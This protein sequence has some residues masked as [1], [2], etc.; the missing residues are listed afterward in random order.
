MPDFSE[1]RNGAEQHDTSPDLICSGRHKGTASVRSTVVRADGSG[2]DMKKSSV[3]GLSL[4]VFLLAC[5]SS[6]SAFA[7]E[8]ADD[9]AAKDFRASGGGKSSRAHAQAQ[10]AK[11]EADRQAALRAAQRAEA[12]AKKAQAGEAPMKAEKVTVPVVVEPV[13]V[14]GGKSSKA[15]AQA[16]AAKAAADRAAA[17]EE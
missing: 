7:A 3:L 16:K 6:L 17:S 2:R 12:R 9:A 14:R 1:T 10:A 8:G 5:V 11:Q 4:R 15:H 13:V